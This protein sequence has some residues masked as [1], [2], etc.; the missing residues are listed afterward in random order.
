MTPALSPAPV[1]RIPPRAPQQPVILD[2]IYSDKL[3]SVGDGTHSKG[4][5]R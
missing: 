3:Q 1:W 2:A 4:H 5:R